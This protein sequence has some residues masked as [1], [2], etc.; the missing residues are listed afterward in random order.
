MRYNLSCLLFEN[1]LFDADLYLKF[2]ITHQK[3]IQNQQPLGA[4][5]GFSNP[6]SFSF[7]SVGIAINNNMNKTNINN[8]QMSSNTNSNT[9]MQS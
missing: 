5:G 3:L 9:E 7:G 8:N 6:Y 4:N 2:D 1:T